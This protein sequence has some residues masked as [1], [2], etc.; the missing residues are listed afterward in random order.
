MVEQ[1][2]TAFDLD[3]VVMDSIDI[4]RMHFWDVFGI[5]MG[6]PKIH[7]NQFNFIE[8][9]SKGLGYETFGPEIP[10][11]LAKYHH[12]I[13]PVEGSI[14][15]LERF[16]FDMGEPLLFVTA[17]EPSHPVKQ[18]TYRWLDHALVG[19]K[20]EVIFVES[21]TDKVQ[22][23]KD[24]GINYFVDDRY[25]TCHTLCEQLTMMFMFNQNWNTGRPV[26]VANI[27]RINDLMEMI[28]FLDHRKIET[29]MQQMQ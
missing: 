13:P 27:Q 8:L 14:K 9:E 12:I 22:V 21:S 20:Y 23:L 10:V 2:D 4:F 17:R 18:A 11:A 15:A 26:K 7:H 25:R 3:G 1:T 5:D 6:E 16:H 28:D 24:R 29:G 19:A